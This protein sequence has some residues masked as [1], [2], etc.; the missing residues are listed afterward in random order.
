MDLGD[1]I[2]MFGGSTQYKSVDKSVLILQKFSKTSWQATSPPI[3]NPEEG[4]P[5]L[6]SFSMTKCN[7]YVILFG[8]KNDFYQF[9]DTWLLHTGNLAIYY[10]TIV[11]CLGVATCYSKAEHDL[12]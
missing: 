9:N 3:V 10:V 4:P 6:R 8:G 5:S 2:L 1:Q 7:D 12:F 11:R